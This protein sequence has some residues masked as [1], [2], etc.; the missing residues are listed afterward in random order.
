MMV[1]VANITTLLIKSL[2]Q[3]IIVAYSCH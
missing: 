1:T 2:Y 3:W